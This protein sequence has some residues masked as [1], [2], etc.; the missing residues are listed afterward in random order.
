MW[1]TNWRTI[2]LI[3]FIGITGIGVGAAATLVRGS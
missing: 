2:A 1:R 3:G